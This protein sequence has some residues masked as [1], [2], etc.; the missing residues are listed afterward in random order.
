ME[1]N[2]ILSIDEYDVTFM[3]CDSFIVSC[4]KRDFNNWVFAY[5]SSANYKQVVK[6][7]KQ[8]EI[9]MNHYQG[10]NEYNSNLE[11]NLLADSFNK[12]QEFIEFAREWWENETRM[13]IGREK[14]TIGPGKDSHPHFWKCPTA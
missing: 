4:E 8:L 1:I 14:V 7:Q 10:N 2:K 3:I 9:M 12:K 5:L 6:A 13:S 11:G